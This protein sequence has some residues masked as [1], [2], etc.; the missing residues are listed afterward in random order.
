MHP[1]ETMIF[2]LREKDMSSKKEPIVQGPQEHAPKFLV[3]YQTIMV[4]LSAL[5]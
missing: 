1:R 4:V 2:F 3:S 5:V